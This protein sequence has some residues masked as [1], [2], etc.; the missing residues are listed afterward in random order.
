MYLV[1]CP[2]FRLSYQGLG[3]PLCFAAFGPFA[4][5]AFYLL[6]SRGRFV[7]NKTLYFLIKLWNLVLI[8]SK[9]DVGWFYSIYSL[10]LNGMILSASLLVG[11]TT[12]LIL[13]CSHFHQVSKH[14]T[15]NGKAERK[16]NPILVLWQS[17]IS[18]MYISYNTWCMF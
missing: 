14:K 5:T 4:T 9:F 13:F 16:S 15:S 18:I 1:Q 11:F 17:P 2:P 3:E 6:Q 8:S 12:T 10:P 7:A